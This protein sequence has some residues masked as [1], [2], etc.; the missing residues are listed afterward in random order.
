MLKRILRSA[1]LVGVVL[2]LLSFAMP[3]ATPT[4][5]ATA[6]WRLASASAD[7]ATGVPAADI[8]PTMGPLTIR[9]PTRRTTP[10][11]RPTMRRPPITQLPARP[12][13]RLQAA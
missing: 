12:T 3:S 6:A 2:S 13:I 11:R 1:V 7:Q 9:I 10:T 4:A 8:D 5:V